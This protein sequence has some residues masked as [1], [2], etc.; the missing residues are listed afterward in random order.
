VG[1]D[2]TIH[3]MLKSKTKIF[4][5]FLVDDLSHIWSTLIEGS[6][7][8]KTEKANDQLVRSVIVELQD[9]TLN[10]LEHLYSGISLNIEGVSKWPPENDYCTIDLVDG[11]HSLLLG[12]S[13]F[14]LQFAVVINGIIE[15][16]V[17]FLPSEQRLG[18]GFHMTKRNMGAFVVLDEN[19]LIQIHTSKTKSLSKATIAY[20][21]TTHAVALLYQHPLTLAVPRVR[22][23]SAFCWAGTRLAR[24]HN[25]PLSIDTVVGINNKPWDHIPSIALIEEAG[26]MV[27]NFQGEPYSLLTCHDLIFSNTHLHSQ[28]VQCLQDNPISYIKKD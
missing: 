3:D 6:L 5:K 8:S 12:T 2:A 24:G 25:L 1:E 16:V 20:D 23:F 18:G 19:T 10:F 9:R 11:T 4:W 14:G 21:G 28:I 13:L 17:I 7:A 27:T 26:G 15:E 22:N